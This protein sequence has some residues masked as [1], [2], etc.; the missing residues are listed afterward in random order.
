[1]A[2]VASAAGLSEGTL[3]NYFRDKQD[4][5]L[6]VS[7]AAFEG[8]IQAAEKAVAESK[9]LRQGLER[10]I[11]IELAL[12]IEAKELFR[13]WMREMR[14]TSGYAHSEARNR[15]A[16]LFIAAH[17]PLREMGRG[18]RSAARP[19]PAAGTR[20][21][22]R[23]SRAH[24]LDGAGAG[25]PGPDRRAENVARPGRCVS[26]CVRPGGRA[27]GKAEKQSQAGAC[28]AGAALAH[29]IPARTRSDRHWRSM[30]EQS[31]ALRLPADDKKR[32]TGTQGKETRRWSCFS[33]W[34]VALRRAVSTA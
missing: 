3:Y 30:F 6:R 33:S 31:K 19:E 2:A 27:H 17:P 23:Q 24:R 21:C 13:I 4:L 5:Q 16:A 20:Y 32:Q 25:S 14:S 1:M 8:H 28:A 22:V 12:L 18:A 29:G 7:L 26:A 11:A 34:S 15:A 9:S 10:L